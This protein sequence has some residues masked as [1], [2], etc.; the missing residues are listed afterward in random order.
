MGI[1]TGA[2]AHRRWQMAEPCF[3][4]R[5]LCPVPLPISVLYLYQALHQLS[6][7]ETK[8]G[9]T[10]QSVSGLLDKA[11]VN[12]FPGIL[13]TVLYL[14]SLDSCCVLLLDS[15]MAGRIGLKLGG[16]VEGMGENVLAKEFFGSGVR[17]VGHN[18]V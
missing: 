3:D 9:L 13:V 12:L 7:T 11:L 6:S 10:S 5:N 4:S 8:S 18:F 16:M 14:K 15:E 1:G 2:W 17:S